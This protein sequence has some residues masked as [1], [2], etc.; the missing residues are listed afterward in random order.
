M[1]AHEGSVILR[2]PWDTHPPGDKDEPHACGTDGPGRG[3]GTS[4]ELLPQ[5]RPSREAGLPHPVLPSH[6]AAHPGSRQKKHTASQLASWAL[7]EWGN[8]L[9]SVQ[10]AAHR[11]EAQRTGPG[12][13]APRAS[14]SMDL[15]MARALPAFP[16]HSNTVP[17]PLPTPGVEAQ[18]PGAPG[19]RRPWTPSGQLRAQV[20]GLWP[21][22][23]PGRA[24]LAPS[25]LIVSM[26]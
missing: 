2:W 11:A 20:Q 22:P 5:P 8:G 6:W 1:E 26:N 4:Q 14:G 18:V 15:D 23:P 10:P 13:T 21:P 16:P 7:H 25:T 17:P 24:L 9:G 3:P 12:M 19:P